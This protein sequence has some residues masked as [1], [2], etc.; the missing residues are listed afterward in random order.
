MIRGHASKALTLLS[1][2]TTLGSADDETWKGFWPGLVTRIVIDLDEL[3]DDVA[4]RLV[5]EILAEVHERL[6]PPMTPPEE[7]ELACARLDAA[8][9]RAQYVRRGNERDMQA[10]EAEY[11]AAQANLRR[12]EASP[13]I[14]L[15][16]YDPLRQEQAA[17]AQC[18]QPGDEESLYP[19]EY[20]GKGCY[21][22]RD[23]VACSE[24][25][26]QQGEK[27]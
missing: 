27:P 22:C 23:S 15:P 1:G 12:F 9:L 7:Y 20:E 14:P 3:G 24:R 19:W 16:Q 10:A 6:V 17:C 18:G 26:R 25:L 13:G 5:A 21:I 11:E 8:D 2:I 4:S